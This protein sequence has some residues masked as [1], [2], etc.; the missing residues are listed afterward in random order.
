MSGC[1]WRKLVCCALLGCGRA[2]GE[3]APLTPDAAPEATAQP[4]PQTDAALV[5]DAVAP[6]PVVTA[7]SWREPRG[8]RAFDNASGRLPPA[9]AAPEYESAASPCPQGMALVEGLRCPEPVQECLRWAD[10]PGQAPR[11]CAE[12]A[13]PSRCV[14]TRHPLR[15][16]VD[17]HEYTPAN[18]ELPLV[19]VSWNEASRLCLQQKKRLCS[20]TEWEFA[21]EGPDALPYPY[22]HV[23]DGGRCNHDLDE[24]FTPRGKLVDRRVAADARPECASPFGVLNMV[25]NV[26]EWTTRTDPGVARRSVLR[27]GWWLVGRNRCRASTS[28]HGEIYAGPQ[29]GFRCCKAAR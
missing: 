2:G 14:G 28:S 12:F 16:C 18:W 1:A 17:V 29:T 10:P 27:G 21:C 6:V 24:L 11:A 23:R 25:G 4:S 19:H 7:S 9:L 22:G 5:P 26:D 8:Q 3:V 15:F 13:A 20:E